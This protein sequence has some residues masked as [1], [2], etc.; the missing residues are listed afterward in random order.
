AELPDDDPTLVKLRKRLDAAIESSSAGEK[1]RTAAMDAEVARRAKE[2]APKRDLAGEIKGMV[3][4][5]RDLNNVS[6]KKDVAPIIQGVCVRC[7]NGTQKAGGFDGSTYAQVMEHIEPGKPESSH[8]LNLV[9]GK[10]EPRMPRGGQTRFDREWVEIWTNWIKQGAKFDGTSKTAPL[11][12]YMIDLE[13]QRRAAILAL[14][15]S[16]IEKLHRTAAERHLQIVASDKKVA[17]FETPNVMA[18]TTLS[19][20]DAEYVGVLAEAL[21]EDLYPKFGGKGDTNVFRGRMGLY[22]F[23][24]RVDYVSFARLV[25]RYSPESGEFGHVRLTPDYSYVAM[26]TDHPTGTLD[27]LVAQQV[28]AAFVQHSAGG[29]A[30]PWVV[31][32]Y[33]SVAAHGIAGKDP[34]FNAEIGRAAQLLASGR[35]FNNLC[36]ENVPWTELGPLASGFFHFLNGT[37]QRKTADFVR[38]YGRTGDWKAAVGETLGASPAELTRA[39]AGWTATKRAGK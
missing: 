24:D 34:M 35:T 12:S 37:N 27:G 20:K 28:A 3:K 1:K 10:A 5:Q 13:S 2:M 15:L 4:V 11:A 16:D 25:D 7:H 21:L 36:G 38:T 22:V 26:T 30:P 17:K 29:K 9:T 18:F 31:Y 6:F 8:L 23:A 39:W 33:S 19:E 32:G 14:P